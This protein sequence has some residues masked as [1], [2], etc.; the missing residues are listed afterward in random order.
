MW[1]EQKVFTKITSRKNEYIKRLRENPDGE[2]ICTGRKMLEEALKSGCEITSILWCEDSGEVKCDN[3][4]VAPKD[5]FDYACPMKN[6]PGPIFTVRLKEINKTVNSAIVLENVQDPGNVGTVIRTANAL[7][8]DAVYLVG[9]CASISNT[10][11]ISATMGAIFYQKIL[12]D[13]LPDLPIF[14][15]ALGDGSKDIRQV[16]LKNCAVAI[17]SEGNGLSEQMLSRCEGKIIIPMTEKAESLNAAV[18]A[19]I[20]M[21]EMTK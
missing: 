19:A 20:C 21:W 16:C 2:I 5:L 9:N 3:Q 15:A 4:F 13:C 12:T 11:T 10:K 18:A 1:K 7:G 8:I 17:G 6:S 14:G